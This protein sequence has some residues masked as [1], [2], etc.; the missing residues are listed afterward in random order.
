MLDT[1]IADLTDPFLSFNDQRNIFT[2]C[3]ALFFL[4]TVV[5]VSRMARRNRQIHVRALIRLVAK[6]SVWLHPSAKLDY[7]MYAVNLVLMAFFLGY[8]TIGLDF[9]AGF[10]LSL[11]RSFLGP[12]HDAANASWWV[13]GGIII[14]EILALDFGYWFGHYTMHKSAILW[15]FHKVHHSAEVMTPATEFRQHPFEL[16]YMPT[17]I[18]FTTGL[19]FAVISHFI[20]QGSDKL[21]LVG[22]NIILI[23]HMFTF[24][25]LRHSHIHMP[26]TGI[27]GRLLHSPMHHIIHHSDNPAHFDRNMGYMLSIWDWF[28]GTL[29]VPHKGERVT[30]GIG[31]EGSLHTTV[32]Q[33]YWLPVRNAALL[34]RQRLDPLF[35]RFAKQEM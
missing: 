33:S 18:G 29:H 13:V 15:E 23:A 6:K 17:I 11:L 1:L 8:F 21:G 9:W 34:A 25:H 16:V 10:F 22:L 7:K 12:A 4:F 31:H 24:H 3:A 27:M 20:G 5:L 26:F 35:A 30:L 28:A 32:G 2:Y 14:T 19:T